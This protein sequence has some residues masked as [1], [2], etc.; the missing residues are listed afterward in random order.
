MKFS[1]RF[2]ITMVLCST[3]CVLTACA[4]VNTGLANGSSKKILLDD[5]I[6]QGWVFVSDDSALKLEDVWHVEDGV[7][8][9]AGKPKG[10]LRTNALFSDYRL[11]LEWRWNAEAGNGGILLHM[12]PGDKVWPRCFQAQLKDEHAGD[13]IAMEGADAYETASQPKHTLPHVSESSEQS[14]GEWNAFEIV[15]KDSHLEFYVN[16]I[17]QNKATE[18]NYVAGPIGLQ[19]E[20]QAID[21]RNIYI[22][23]L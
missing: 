6:S 3:Y 18:L 2:L 19:L 21:Y 8:H 11:H 12:Q 15:A 5:S 1:M 7:L 13:L 17:L 23:Y 9:V 20:G 14:V 16:G 10:Y 4:A 22:E